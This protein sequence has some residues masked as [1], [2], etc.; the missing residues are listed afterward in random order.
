MDH[1]G[2]LNPIARM[3]HQPRIA[4]KIPNPPATAQEMVI[5]HRITELPCNAQR[6]ASTDAA[7]IRTIP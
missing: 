5:T 3:T 1:I 7:A 2:V 4:S 6:K